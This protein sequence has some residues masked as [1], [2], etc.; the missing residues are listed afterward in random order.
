MANESPTNYLIYYRE[1][2][3]FLMALVGSDGIVVGT[4]HFAARDVEYPTA[5]LDQF[6]LPVA[7]RDRILK[8]N[9]MKLLHL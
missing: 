8:G 1:A 3:R 4:D 5:V 7:D 2:F 9:A 6:N